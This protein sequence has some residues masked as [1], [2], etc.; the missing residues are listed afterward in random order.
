MQYLLTLFLLILFT[1]CSIKYDQNALNDTS[2][3]QKIY[4]LS[5]ALQ[6]L[7]RNVNKDEAHYIATV[8][9]EYPLELANKYELVSPPLWHNTLINMNL[10]ERGFCYHF[11]QDLL[12]ELKKRE[13]KTLNLKW[14]THK[15]NNY[16]EHNSVLITAKKQSYQRGI[17]LDPWRDSGKLYWNYLHKDT[18]YDWTLDQQ[19]TKYY[20]N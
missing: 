17:I 14:A 20:G 4:A 12:K 15:K 2:K 13:F 3:E 8:A 1:G 5:Q 10:K 9:Y 7:D 16:W 19:K 18:Q 6:Q 11:A